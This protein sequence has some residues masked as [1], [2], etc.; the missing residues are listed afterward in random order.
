MPNRVDL[1]SVSKRYL[2]GGAPVLDDISLTLQGGT[3][4]SI[5]GS[6]GSGKSTLLRLLAGYLQKVAIAQAFAGEPALLILDEPRTGLDSA[7][8]AVLSQL[9]DS[10]RERG[11]IIL[12]AAPR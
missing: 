11:A 7:A 8:I 5:T 9:V 10:S 6:N 12:P 4:T 2:R 1:E 3:S